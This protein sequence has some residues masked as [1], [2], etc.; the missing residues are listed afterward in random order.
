MT[1]TYSRIDG[2]VLRSKIEGAMLGQKC[3]GAY[4]IPVPVDPGVLTELTARQNAGPPDG[5]LELEPDL[6][7]QAREFLQLHGHVFGKDD[8]GFVDDLQSRQMVPASSEPPSKLRWLEWTGPSSSHAFWRSSKSGGS[9]SRLTP[10]ARKV[11]NAASLPVAKFKD[12]II[13]AVKENAVTI[14]SGETGSGKTTQV[15]NYILDSARAAS[16]HGRMCC[17]GVAMPRRVA[18]IAAAEFVASERGESVGQSVGY[19]VR[20]DEGMPTS[21]DGCVVFATAGALRRR[22]RRC[23]SGLSHLIIDEAHERDCDAD[24]LL[25]VAREILRASQKTQQSVFEYEGLRLIIMS[26]TLDANRLTQYFMEE[27]RPLTYGA[28][29]HLTADAG[30]DEMNEIPCAAA[31]S[32]QLVTVPGRTFPIQTLHLEDIIEHLI[33]EGQPLS[34]DEAG[35]QHPIPAVRASENALADW[36]PLAPEYSDETI[37][38]IRRL[39]DREIPLSVLLAVLR[40]IV[41]GPR[42]K[43]APPLAED[44]SLPGAVEGGAVLVFLP[45]RAAIDAAH[46][47]LQR[48]GVVGRRCDIVVLHADSPAVDQHRAFAPAS[49]NMVKVV[50]STSVAESSITIADITFVVDA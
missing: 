37:A 47:A 14:I 40:Q 13:N 24:F 48:D 30:G 22:L 43:I 34:A 8:E 28:E 12:E 26:A 45:G 11:S 2:G 4:W 46:R 5:T 16:A 6:E 15:P 18:A 29:G 19:M 36:H 50:L 27:L 33:S 35:K 17:I 39:D 20:N 10:K 3:S 38:T 44:G 32:V 41:N 7:A 1:D 23:A 25:L 42:G 49:N 9:S 31:N 21:Q